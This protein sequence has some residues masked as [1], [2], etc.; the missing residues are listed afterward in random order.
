[1]VVFHKRRRAL[2]SSWWALIPLLAGCESTPV[3]A[4]DAG[5][6]D[7]GSR[8]ADGGTGIADAQPDDAGQ[9][10]I[11]GEAGSADTR[12][13]T[14]PLGQT[15]VTLQA[16][17][18]CQR[19]YSLSS[20]AILRDNQPENPRTISELE[21]WPTLRS[22][23]E[24]FDALYAL[25]LEESRQLGVDAIRDGAF[26]DGQPV[27]CGGC[28]ETGRLWNYVWTRDT[29]YAMHLGL[30]GIDPARAQRSLDFKLSERRGGGDL[31]I[32]QDTG[33]G[34]SYPISTDRVA[35]ALGAQ[36]VLN[37]LEGEDRDQFAAR[38]LSALTHTLE[39][40]RIVVF[41]EDDGLYRGEQSFL[42]WRQQSYPEWTAANVGHIGMSK[43]LS[44]NLLHY[45]AMQITAS[46]AE[47]LGDSTRTAE[48][49]AWAVELKAAIQNEFWLADE[50]LFSTYKTTTLDPAPVRRYDLLGSAFAVT[51]GVA[52]SAQATQILSKYPHYGPGAPVIWPQQQDVPIYHNRGEWPFVTAYWLRAAQVA[53]HAAVAERMVGALVRGAALNLSNM[54]NFEAG[55][56]AAW[57]DE[58]PSSGPVVNSQR[59]LWSVAGYLSMVQHTLFGLQ[60]GADG[61]HVRP[62][63]TS[64]LRQGLFANTSQLILNNYRYRG[65]SVDVVLHLP[66]EPGTG[67][68]TV[69]SITLNGAPVSGDRLPQLAQDD[70]IDVHLGP[71]AG[72]SGVLTE[73]SDEDWQNVFGPKTPRITSVTLE[74]D[75]LSL[76][77]STPEPSQT[78]LRIY[79]DGQI[80]ADELPGETA[81]WQD[82]EY[83]PA[84]TASPCY[85]VEATFEI[86][87]NH[88][89]PGPPQCWWGSNYQRIANIDAAE[90]ENIG[91]SGSTEHGEFHYE[92]WGAPGDS[93][94][95]PSFT[96]TQDGQHLLQVRFGNGSGGPDTGITC[97]VKQ[98]R[99]QDVLTG[100]AV[101]Q[102]FFVMPHLGDWSQ[103]ADSNFVAAELSAGRAYRISIA[104]DEMALNMSAFAHFE[105]Y[106]GGLGGRSG[107]HNFV[108]ISKL[109]ILA[110]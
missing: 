20:T 79:R 44:T 95:L 86:S 72:A 87:Q 59:Q 55:S 33:T 21:G 110:R 56:G 26:N 39:H 71:G 29:A 31:Q 23:N 40:D 42:D 36:A 27:D 8:L 62:F 24:L 89:Q 45:R 85:V 14:D 77:L 82:L 70:R 88:S 7:T 96:P 1:M 61:L 97:A 12:S 68:L 3:G 2:R 76:A 9:D 11:V 106:T 28:F 108:N 104:S 107:P 57:L 84:G 93:L 74:G 34:G 49:S 81:V 32:V 35:W 51:F 22:G 60:P 90:L 18:S 46:I 100:D 30:A 53:G 47:S 25:A 102:G 15:T 103:W 17:D 73:T 43:A 101:G 64:G 19:T 94:T 16:P 6:L 4:G 99:V 67:V 41:D 69:A 91:G 5:L 83:D 58:G 65:Q 98:V 75:R 52:D 109:K 54:E 78:S 63:M 105:A 48:F 50:G 10:C 80:V 38:A 92:P 66:S 37:E 13:Y